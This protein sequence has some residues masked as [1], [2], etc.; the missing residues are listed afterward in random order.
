MFYCRL[1]YKGVFVN[2]FVR[3]ER[4]TRTLF[5]SEGSSQSHWTI[6]RV[7]LDGHVCP[8]VCKSTVMAINKEFKQNSQ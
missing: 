7:R 4:T 5:M 3:C 2:V 6:P 8:V 1:L